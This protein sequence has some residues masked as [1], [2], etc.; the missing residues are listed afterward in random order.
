[1]DPKN[2]PGEEE[3]KMQVGEGE[4]PFQQGAA[5]RPTRA[6]ICTKSDKPIQQAIVQYLSVCSE[7]RTV[8]YT[9]HNTPMT[10]TLSW[11][12]IHFF[13]TLRLKEFFS[14]NNRT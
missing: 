14:D 8:I 10:L 9:H 4:E 7:Q 6:R 2:Y 3:E 1:M 12:F 11:I 5:T 13:Q